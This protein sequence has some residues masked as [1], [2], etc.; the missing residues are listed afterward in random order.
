MAQLTID[1]PDAVA[2]RVLTAFCDA[3]GWQAGSGISRQQFMKRAVIDYIKQAVRSQE[4]RQAAEV[5]ARQAETAVDND[6]TLT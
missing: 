6:I 4:S 2:P 1:I 5:A 3:H